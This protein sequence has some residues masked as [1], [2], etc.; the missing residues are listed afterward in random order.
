MPYTFSQGVVINCRETRPD[1]ETGEVTLDVEVYTR[2][3][4]GEDVDFVQVLRLFQKVLRLKDTEE[5]DVASS[6]T[7]SP[8]R[9]DGPDSQGAEASA[10]LGVVASRED[11]EDTSTTDQWA[12]NHA[13]IVREKL[14]MVKLWR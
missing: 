2:E 8:T 12:A 7:A 9:R 1:E 6:S 14:Q 4:A 11:S 13:Q 10:S 5:Q 3:I